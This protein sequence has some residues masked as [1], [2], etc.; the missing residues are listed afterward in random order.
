MIQS[1]SIAKLAVALSKA[2]GTMKHAV[3]DADNPFFRSKYADLASVVEAS[4]PSLVENGLSVVQV[5]EGK[6]LWTML[7]HESG[8]WIKGSIELKPMRQV[9]DTGWVASE[10]PQSYGSCI[11]YARRYAMAAITGVATEDDDGNAASG[12]RVEKEQAVYIKK[13]KPTVVEAEVVNPVAG[14]PPV[15]PSVEKPPTASTPQPEKSVDELRAEL[16]DLANIACDLGLYANTGDAIQSFASDE[17]FT[18]KCR[19]ASG[20][21][22]D[23]AIKKAIKKA[24]AEIDKAPPAE[25]VFG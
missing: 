21:N 5:T 18:S 19:D 11:T 1:E 12:N 22:K 4:R 14:S 25:E 7:L 23:W 9:K 20:M 8:E 24:Q 10:D 16:N 13:Q 6:V 15:P 3:K 17:K 2:Q